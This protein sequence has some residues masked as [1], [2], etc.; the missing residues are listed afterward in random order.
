MHA[1]FEGRFE[2][3]ERLSRRTL[4]IGDRMPG[5]DAGGV[6]G[7]QMFTLRL[8]QGRLDEV[9]PLVSH[10][11]KSNAQANIWRPGLALIY[12]ELGQLEAARTQFDSLAADGFRGL[13]R[14]G[15]WVASI[16]YLAQVCSA[17]GDAKRA[18]VLYPLL[19][20]YS[21]RNLLAGTSIACFGA[22]DAFLGSL[23]A[24]MKR[25]DDAERHFLAALAMNERQGA[26]P[27]LARTRFHYAAMLLACHG[28]G[29]RQL[30]DNLLE[31]AARDAAA[32]GMRSLSQRI[33]ACHA[34]RAAKPAAPTYP[35]G[36]S[37]REAQVLSFVAEGKSNRQIAR[38]LFVSPNTIANHVRSILSKTRS[39]NRTEAAAFAIK[40]ALQA[41]AGHGG[42]R[43]AK[44]TPV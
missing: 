25:W 39:N 19:Q 36:L 40:H 15:V 12:A 13:V 24:T 44:N 31:A 30:A 1:L 11:V 23:C 26:R 29:G 16:A 41:H 17:L 5:L 8:E 14:D 7:V 9:A 27:A 37:E 6:Y 32:L 2:D 33:A 38:E 20:P 43:N 34:P 42:N 22:A 4:E 28:A 10:F 18:E 35:A 3:A 21:G